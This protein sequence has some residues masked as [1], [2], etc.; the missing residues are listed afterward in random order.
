MTQFNF[1]VNRPSLAMKL[2][3]GNLLWTMR[4]KN[5]NWYS[6]AEKKKEYRLFLNDALLIFV[7]IIKYSFKKSDRRNALWK[8]K[9][10]DIFKF[11]PKFNKL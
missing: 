7:H 6:V 1:S 3:S 10:Y 9:K 5:H 8:A 11:S 2:K 4:K